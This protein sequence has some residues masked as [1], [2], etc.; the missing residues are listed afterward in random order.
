MLNYQRVVSRVQSSSM[1]LEELVRGYLPSKRGA[2]S[3]RKLGYRC[4]LQETNME[5]GNSLELV[6]RCL[7]QDWNPSEKKGWKMHVQAVVRSAKIG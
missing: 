3:R 4:L 1:A 2:V 6:G 7:I 5:S